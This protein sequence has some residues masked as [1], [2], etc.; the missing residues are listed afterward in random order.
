VRSNL[1]RN[2][3]IFLS[4]IAP[5]GIVAASISS[6][7]AY[8]LV[9]LGRADAGI[10]APLIFLV[11]VGTV[12]AQGL[13]AKPLAR[14]LGVSEADPQGVL[15]M[16]ANRFA[17]DLA[18]A[19]KRAGIAVRLVDTNRSNVMQ[20]RLDGLD[21]VQGNILSDQ[22]EDDLD[23]AGL[24]RLLALTE[25]DEANALAC[26]H[27]V[28]DFGSA[29]VYQLP[30][31]PAA[32]GS[33]APSEPHLGRLLFAPGATSRELAARLERGAVIKAT[34]LTDKYTWEHFQREQ[35]ERSLPLL[36][37]RSGHLTVATVDKPLK[38]ATGS[39]VV[40]LSG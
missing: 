3:R 20:A 13:T 33:R 5:R 32:R 25:N 37:V 11:I 31:N 34:V 4:W 23:F 36:A 19:L 28:E 10:I 40:A 22:V 8:T 17:R 27:F 39:A 38:P 35:G 2:E 29:R 7:F 9:S 30:P 18:A 6:L 16:S 14:R 15:L 24:G 26:R 1:N 21:A 12:L